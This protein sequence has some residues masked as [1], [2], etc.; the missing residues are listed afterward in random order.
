MINL[1]MLPM[2]K[3][4]ESFRAGG[5]I[6]LRTTLLTWLV[7]ILSIMIFAAFLIPF[8]KAFFIDSLQVKA[9]EMTASVR[10]TLIG[11]VATDDYSD[12]VSHCLNTV[13]SDPTVHYLVITRCDGFSLLHT[14]DHWKVETL[15][16]PWV[17]GASGNVPHGAITKPTCMAPRSTTM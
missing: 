17:S 9:Q 1:P 7:T 2:P 5:S 12:V 4:P 16:T 10:H 6:A 3:G 15:G 14:P 8:Q 13:S 11:A